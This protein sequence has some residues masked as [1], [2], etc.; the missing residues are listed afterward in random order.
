VHFA[1]LEQ[2]LFMLLSLPLLIVVVGLIAMGSLAMGIAIVKTWQI[3]RLLQHNWNPD[4]ASDSGVR[5]WRYLSTLMGLFLGG[6]CLAAYLI[7][8]LKLD[9]L[10]LLTGTVFFFGSL[11][12]L[13]SLNIYRH[14]LLQLI[15]SQAQYREERDRSTAA[16]SQLQQIQRTQSQLIHNE[17]ML[18]LGQLSAGIAHEINNPMG[19]IYSNL[20]PVAQYTA[21]LFAL[22]KAYQQ[23]ELKPNPTIAQMTEE[24]DLPFMEDDFFKILES[25][26][27]GAQRVRQIVNSMR[28]FTRLDESQYKHASLHDD[29][30][31]TLVMLQSL[32]NDGFS[33]IE[34]AIAKQYESLPLVECDHSA[35]NQVF[36]QLIKNSIES[37]RLSNQTARCAVVSIRTQQLD[38]D[39]V[40]IE[41]SDNGPGITEETLRHIFDPFFTTKPVGQGTG[42]GLA[43]SHQIV[44]EQH[45]GKLHCRSQTGQGTI[46]IIELPICRPRKLS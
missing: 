23:T 33:S 34:I 3:I 10:P 27:I 14:T 30:D 26:K 17:K 16:L 1:F 31:S 18:S 39:W 8:S 40:Q 19:F 11:F 5:N 44:V 2:T 25:M 7:A 38:Q 15:A 46:S 43:I 21:D 28:A 32:L 6:Y 45:Q 22:I 12:V 35:M 4:I 42:L 9:W 41:I 20:A 36:F 24:I 13:F 37:F 29:L